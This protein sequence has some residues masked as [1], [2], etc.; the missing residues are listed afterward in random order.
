[1]EKKFN[2]ENLS[3]RTPYKVPEGYFE[4]LTSKVMSQIPET[5]SVSET[6]SPKKKEKKVVGMMPHRRNTK[7]IKWGVAI[8]ACVCGIALFLTNGQKDEASSPLASTNKKAGT[9][10]VQVE[11]FVDNTTPT[12][13]AKQYANN[14]YDISQR[15]KGGAYTPE[16]ARSNQYVA[17]TQSERVVVPEPSV[18]IAS[19]PTPAT[20]QTS[21]AKQSSAEKAPSV[22]P[23]AQ[24]STLAASLDNMNDYDLLD[25]TQMSGSEIYDYLAGNEYY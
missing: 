25:Y 17:Y 4:G 10:D 13:T 15:R 19:T 2:I 8:A 24:V 11:E 3:K 23:S 14:A 9:K 18:R 20:K 7:W 21:V 12:Q 5:A 6:V 1:M 16:P 22:Q